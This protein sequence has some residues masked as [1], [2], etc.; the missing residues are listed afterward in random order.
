MICF[1]QLAYQPPSHIQRDEKVIYLP[2]P[3]KP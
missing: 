1:L 2:K 3:V